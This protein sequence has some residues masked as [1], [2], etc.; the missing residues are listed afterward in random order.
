MQTTIFG[1]NIVGL[2]NVMGVPLD[3][4]CV[5]CPLSKSIVNQHLE[6]V[7]CSLMV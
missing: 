7:L 2:L 6:L 3:F 4:L 5:C 1:T